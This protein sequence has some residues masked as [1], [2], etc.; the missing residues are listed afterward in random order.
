MNHQEE[1][2]EVLTPLPVEDIRVVKYFKARTEGKSKSTALTEA[3]YADTKHASRIEQ[4]QAYQNVSQAFQS[5]LLKALPL[6]DIAKLIKRNS[7]QSRDIGGSNGALK[8]A[9]QQIDKDFGDERDDMIV[10]LSGDTK[11]FRIKN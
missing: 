9:L 10:L 2:T 6:N 5:A 7:S 1:K 8:L 4:T 3:G 11:P